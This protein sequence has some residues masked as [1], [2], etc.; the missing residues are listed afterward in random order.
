[1]KPDGFPAHLVRFHARSSVGGGFH[2][3]RRA[4]HAG[5]N[6]QPAPGRRNPIQLTVGRNFTAQIDNLIRIDAGD[7]RRNR[8]AIEQRCFTAMPPLAGPA[9]LHFPK[10]H[11]RFIQDLDFTDFKSPRFIHQDTNS[12]RRFGCKRNSHGLL[13]S[14][15]LD[16]DTKINHR[17]L[18]ERFAVG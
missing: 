16:A 13:V 15:S 17:H 2:A 8:G 1:M 5:A 11:A 10:I 12:T 9:G 14:T 7:I 18:M 6:Q 4:G 3:P